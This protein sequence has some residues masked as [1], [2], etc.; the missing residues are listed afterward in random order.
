MRLPSNLIKPYP[1]VQLGRVAYFYDKSE[2]FPIV[3]NDEGKFIKLD[4]NFAEVS[5]VYQSRTCSGE[6]SPRL[7][8]S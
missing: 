3:S 8:I 4:V 5:S 2:M 7:Q 6:H 1:S